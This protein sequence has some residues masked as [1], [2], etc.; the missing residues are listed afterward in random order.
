MTG[1]FLSRA[2]LRRDTSVDALARLLVPEHPA[3]RAAVSHRLVWALFADGA[4]WTRD[5]LWRDE[6]AGKF[7]T[8]SARPPDDPPGL[9]DLEWK[10]FAPILS[11]GDRLAFTPRANPVVARSTGPGIR[12]NR[13]DLVMDLLYRWPDRERAVTRPEAALIAGRAWIARQGAACGFDI[14]GDAA[15]DGY[16]QVR[17]PRAGGR[18]RLWQP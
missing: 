7:M 18:H 2:R 14:L 5:F 1:L 10:P 13:H 17:V 11:A 9:F 4:D 6:E 3:D 12:S 8:L 15:V 16:D